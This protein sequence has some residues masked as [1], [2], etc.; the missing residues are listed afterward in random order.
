MK[1]AVKSVQCPELYLGPVGGSPDDDRSPGVVSLDLWIVPEPLV[2][3]HMKRVEVSMTLPDCLRYICRPV[4][5][6]VG[7]VE[8]EHI[9]ISRNLLP[10]DHAV[11]SKRRP[12]ER[13]A[14]GRG[15]KFAKE[16]NDLTPRHWVHRQEVDDVRPVLTVLVAVAHQAG[17][18]R[19]AIRL[20]TDQDVAEV[21]AS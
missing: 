13:L 18:D 1:S 6:L 9:M 21:F 16:P 12:S 7:R 20:V 2:G 11:E 8:L 4:M 14:L 3:G 5:T 17:G 15:F 19:V 10:C